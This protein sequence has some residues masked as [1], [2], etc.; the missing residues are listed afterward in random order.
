MKNFS[1]I[2]RKWQEIW[3]NARVF[4]SAPDS[5]KPKYYVLEMFPYPSGKIHVGHLRNY[6]MGDVIARFY[7]AAGY[8]VLYPMGWDAFGLP[9]ENA[10][11]LN[12]TH[13]S[14]WTY[15]NI[16]SM[17]E[18]IKRTGNSYNWDREITTCDPS[19]YQHEQEFF[20]SLFKK[21][22]AYQQESVVN[23]DPID[24]TVLANEQVIDG[25]G[26]RSGA[27]VEK[28]SLKQWF[29][30]ITNYAEELLQETYNLTEWPQSVRTMQQNWIG[31][32]TG[33]NIK[34]KIKNSDQFLEVYS[35]RPDTLFGCTFIAICYDHYALNLAKPT[36]EV[37]NFISK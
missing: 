16:K 8:N 1:A 27:L 24:N 23:W 11:I 26:W 18:Q 17:K 13:P 9:A 25:R 22:L 12:K 7:R 21:G 6:T 29:L 36:E 20:I 5:N 15:E 19:C 30:K 31:K 33:A 35:T 2:D 34:F 3:L 4:H 28:R 37:V 32:S 10:A 14:S